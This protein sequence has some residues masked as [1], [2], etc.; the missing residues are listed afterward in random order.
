MLLQF[1]FSNYK[2]FKDESI[3]NL[4]APNTA[5]YDYYSHKTNFNNAVLKTATVYGANAS[6]KTKLFEAF[7]FMKSVVCP[8]RGKDKIPVLD[9]WQTK[10]NA[11]RLN[12]YSLEKNSF[13]E[14]VF[15]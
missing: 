2:S 12:T 7:D 8:P 3:L 6:G 5:K 1:S 9:Y 13:F 11:F 10:Y 14:A 15:T 4:I